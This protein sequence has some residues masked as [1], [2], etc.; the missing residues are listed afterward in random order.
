[1][2]LSR[3]QIFLVVSLL[4]AALAGC[5]GE[6]VRQPMQYAAI[7]PPDGQTARTRADHEE[8]AAWYE[9]EAGWAAD[10]TAVHRGMLAL[11]VSPYPDYG[12]TGFVGHCTNLVQRYR[13]AAEANRVLAALHRAYAETTE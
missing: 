13:Q 9:R 4:P 6:P 2:T 3:T 12:N 5:A 8:I 11:Y 10:R 1:M 7:G